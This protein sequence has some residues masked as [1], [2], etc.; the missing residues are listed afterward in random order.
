MNYLA[1][2]VSPNAPFRTVQEMIDYAKS[3]KGELSF[4]S[5]GEG[6]FPHMSMEMLRVQAGFFDYV[7]VPYKGAAR[8]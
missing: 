5:N 2:V 7:H 8:S 1:L 4:A 3:S 6:G